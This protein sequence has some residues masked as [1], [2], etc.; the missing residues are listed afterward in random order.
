M[1]VVIIDDDELS[2]SE[3]SAKLKEYPDV[4][5]AGVTTSANK[6]LEYIRKK[7]PDVAFLDVEMPEMSG[8]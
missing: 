5:I 6:G 3:L 8:M 7:S 1:D 2:I 4:K